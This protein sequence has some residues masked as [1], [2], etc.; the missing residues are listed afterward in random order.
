MNELAADAIWTVLIF[1]K[2]LTKFSFVPGGNMLFFLKLM[3]TV[4]E[5]TSVS[6]RAT[7]LLDPTL[8][9]LCLYLEL[10]VSGHDATVALECKRILTHPE[11]ILRRISISVCE[12][13]RSQFGREAFNERLEVKRMHT[14][15]ILIDLLRHPNPLGMRILVQKVVLVIYLLL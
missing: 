2:L 6:V 10:V 4:S 9:Q 12:L 3:L 11:G 15:G 14:L 7:L 5:C 1:V 13:R 8:A